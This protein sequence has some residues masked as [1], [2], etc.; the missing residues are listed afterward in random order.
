MFEVKKCIGFL[1]NTDFWYL[2]KIIATRKYTFYS[3][4]KDIVTV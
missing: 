1:N 2:P 4:P 3:V